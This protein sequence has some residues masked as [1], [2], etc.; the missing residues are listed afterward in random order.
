MAKEKLEPEIIPKKTCAVEV[1]KYL[2]K[3]RLMAFYLIAAVCLVAVFGYISLWA[4]A[5]SAGIFSMGAS[6]FIWKDSQKM[7][8][9]EKTY[10]IG[11][12]G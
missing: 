7:I 9:L 12:N 2:K 3:S 4:G 5:L 6:V 8:Y 10:Q 11:K 1:H